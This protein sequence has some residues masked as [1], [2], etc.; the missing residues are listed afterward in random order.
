MKV[1]YMN[2]CVYYC[3][4]GNNKLY[5]DLLKLSLKSINRVFDKNKIFVYTDQDLN[6]LSH[7]AVIKNLKFPSGFAIPMAYRLILGKE[8]LNQYDN[9]LHLDVDTIISKQLD[10]IF[11][12][13]ENKKISFA[14]ENVDNPDKI[15]DNYW[16]G[17]LLSID[18]KKQY[19]E[20]NSICCG[21]FGF[22]KSCNEII[23]NI[24]GY[25]SEVENNNFMGVCRDQHGFAAYVLRNNYYNYNL[26][27]YLSHTPIK[28]MLKNNFNLNSDICIYHFAG[29]VVPD[30]KYEYMLNLYKKI[31]K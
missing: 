27:K 10:D 31:I 21:V 5:F 19:S 30:N 15:I 22:N 25:I 28:L 20:I 13:I 11:S 16:A 26:Q 24:Y 3:F 12:C 7:L 2:N 23:E 18:E 8:L 6:E 14:T 1:K 29:G 4:Y 17:P 9:V